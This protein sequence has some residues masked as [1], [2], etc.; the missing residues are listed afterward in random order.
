MQRKSIIILGLSALAMFL[1]VGCAGDRGLQGEPGT[2]AC[3]G[4]HDDT[5]LEFVAIQQQWE[6]SAHASGANIDRSTVPCV[7]CHTGQGFLNMIGGED[8]V[9]VEDPSAIHCFVCH[10]PHTDGNFNLRVSGPVT[11]EQGG[12][13]DGYGPASLCASCHQARKPSP[14]FSDADSIR[15]TS[16]RWGPHHS[17]QADVFSGQHAYVFPGED[18]DSISPHNQEADNACLACHMAAPHGDLA[19]GHSFNLVYEAEG[20]E[21]QLT[22]G[23]NVEA[24]HAN[25]LEDFNYDGVQDS[26][27]ALLANLRTILI[28]NNLLTESNLVNASSSAPLNIPMD[29]AGAIYNFLFFEEDRSEGVHNPDYT[30][31]VLNASIEYMSS[32]TLAMQ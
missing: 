24:C 17:V 18:Y 32:R 27:A 6:N 20:E 23:C 8:T 29:V 22:T 26:V 19:G 10:A 3:F 14:F 28:N 2:T 16:S 1:V 30:I 21:A 4:C 15:I 7:R 9:A 31:D 5:N 25:N 11:L 13:F 12:T